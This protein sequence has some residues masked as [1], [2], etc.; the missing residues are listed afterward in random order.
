M[1]FTNS[2]VTRGSVTDA[3]I[4]GVDDSGRR[5][6]PVEPSTAPTVDLWIA[7]LAGQQVW[8]DSE[9]VPTA[10]NRLSAGVEIGALL[11][12]VGAIWAHRWAGGGVQSHWV[13][14]APIAFSIACCV[15]AVGPLR[16]ALG[17][18]A[19][20]TRFAI[21][22]PLRLLTIVVLVGAIFAALASW[23]PLI[24]WPFGVALGGD[25]AITS[26]AIGWYPTPLASYTRYLRSAIHLGLLG[27]LVGVFASR[28]W[29]TG[30]HAALPIYVTF[31][32]WVLLGTLTASWLGV[33]RRKERLGLHVAARSAANDEH[34]RAAHWLHDDV[35]AELRLVAIRVQGRTADLDEVKDMLD[36]L[37]HHLRLRQLDELLESGSVR[38]AEVLQPYVRRAQNHASIGEVPSFDEASLIV[39]AVT[40]RLFGHT[41]AVL[42]SNA[43]NAGASVVSFEISSTDGVVSIA[44]TDD[45]G[46]FR[47][48]ELPDGRGLWTL[49]T[50]PKVRSI[51]I[52]DTTDGSRVRVTISIDRED[53][54]GAAPA[55]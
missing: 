38:L 51:D 5:F 17:R 6:Q 54:R 4:V 11:A 34:R 30:Q 24:M 28:G 25:A 50:N 37:D 19:P 23:W 22:V 8:A 46:G 7:L 40:G 29:H 2:V 42:T 9:Q 1:A 35:C 20:S 16:T 48:K 36:D 55:R 41:A 52:D 21:Q 47:S 13:D 33:L 26:W 53:R 18:P 14:T 49:R 45:A 15:V 39:D 12:A 3:V 32:I 27:G 43:L 31:Q 44:V 10:I